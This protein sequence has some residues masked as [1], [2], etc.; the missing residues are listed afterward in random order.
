MS[1]GFVLPCAMLYFIPVSQLRSAD[2]KTYSDRWKRFF[3]TRKMTTHCLKQ[4]CRSTS[5]KYYCR[6]LRHSETTSRVIF[7]WLQRA[8]KA[9]ADCIFCR[10]QE[11]CGAFLQCQ[12]KQRPLPGQRAVLVLLPW[13]KRHG[14]LCWLASPGGAE[15]RCLQLLTL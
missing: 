6:L 3:F 9:R 5:Q 1:S 13:K 2:K 12:S 4:Q 8:I 7:R 14:S 15:E 11:K 10:T